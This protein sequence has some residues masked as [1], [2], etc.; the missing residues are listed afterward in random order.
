MPSGTSA[1]KEYPVQLKD[2]I[3]LAKMPISVYYGDNIPTEISDNPGQDN[4]SLWKYTLYALR[5]E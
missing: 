1:L 4:W 3:Q 2:F 5:L